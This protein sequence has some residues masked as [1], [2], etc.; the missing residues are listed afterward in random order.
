M[1]A[2][3]GGWVRIEKLSRAVPGFRGSVV[4]QA[5]CGAQFDLHLQ[6]RAAPRP[7]AT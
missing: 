7:D 6:E 3:I 5:L 2:D 4:L 1:V